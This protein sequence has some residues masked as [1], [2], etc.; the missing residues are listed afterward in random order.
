MTTLDLDAIKSRA[1]RAI[2]FITADPCAR[3]DGWLP[4]SVREHFT[5]DVPAL[6]AEVERLR[7]A[8][9]AGDAV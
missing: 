7:A 3:G 9:Q 5:R 6:I 4:L 1:G 8:T 2:A